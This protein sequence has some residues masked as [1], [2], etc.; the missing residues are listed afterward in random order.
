MKITSK[1][2]Y[3]LADDSASHYHGAALLV[4]KRL[5]KLTYNPK[6]DDPQRQIKGK[7]VGQ[8][9]RA[10]GV[11]ERQLG[12]VLDHLSDVLEFE[13]YG[14]KIDFRLNLEPLSKLASEG[15]GFRKDREHRTQKA[16]ETRAAIRQT[17]QNTLAGLV[18]IANALFGPVQRKPILELFPKADPAYVKTVLDKARAAEGREPW[19]PKPDYVHVYVAGQLVEETLLPAVA[20]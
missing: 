20:A 8:L 14:R 16:R 10:A 17:G 3:K 18:A 19:I 15:T 7:N 2:A 5:I 12:R 1:E 9:M 11:G 13:R 4:L 6:I